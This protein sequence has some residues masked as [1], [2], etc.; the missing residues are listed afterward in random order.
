MPA[1]D[2]VGHLHHL[3]TLTHVPKAIG[4]GGGGGGG[5]RTLTHH[6]DLL[7]EEAD[8]QGRIQGAKGAEAPLQVNEMRNTHFD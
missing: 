8:G 1:H 6:L 7:G 4:G 5:G 2:Q 3:R